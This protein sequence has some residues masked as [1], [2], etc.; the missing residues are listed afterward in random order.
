MKTAIQN[1]NVGQGLAPK[2]K[3]AAIYVRCS[4]DEAGKE[5]YSPETQEEKIK[6]FAKNE[7]W[8][9]NEESLYKDIGF[10]GGT[11]K[12]PDLQRLLKDA[13][14]KKIDVIIVYRMD[15]FFRNL[16]LLLNTVAE[17]RDIGIE[18]K[19]VTEPFD[20]STP[21]GRAMFANAGVFAEWMREVGL[22]SRNEG[23]VKAMKE[24]KYLGGTAPYGCKFN[25]ET[26]KLEIEK[27]EIKIVKMMFEWL[28][29]EGLSEYKIQQRLNTMKVPTKFDLIGRKKITET[30]G[31]WNRKTVDRILS[32]EVYTGTFYY[33]KYL[34]TGRTKN[35]SNLRPKEDWIKVEDKSLKVISKE[36]FEKGQK[37]LKK[38]K[39]Q[40]IRN[41]KEIYTLQ[42]K[43]VCGYD[44]YKYQ[45]ANRKYKTDEGEKRKTKYYFCV[46]NRSYMTARRCHVP[47]VSE[48][49]IMPPVWDKLKEILIE[50]EMALKQIE[51][52]KNQGDD[53]NIP[54]RLDIIKKELSAQDEKKERYAE[55]Y[56]EKSISKNFYDKKIK[57]CDDKAEKLH[58]E[59]AKIGRIATSE[60]EKE[61]QIMSIKDIY[62]QLKDGLENATYEEKREVLQDLV[63]KV[64]K[65]DDK[66]EIEFLIPLR[67]EKGQ[68]RL[69][70]CSDNPRMD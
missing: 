42:H 66:L 1:Y 67:G 13:R 16:R 17:L 49:R 34:H 5:G 33:R 29:S 37:Q 26:Q 27:N 52:C 43:I 28:V 41:T 2:I 47:T 51:A 62:E 6:S 31:W 20:T 22:E 7:G 56:A 9:I 40:A 57:E 8:E 48:S 15:R 3:R 11:E 36:I 19:S 54:E 10:S 12:R 55:L 38:N 61:I 53:T 39:E 30:K 46:G 65:T 24:G 69:S 45:S 50:P 35:E 60:Q 44:G 4:S 23:M 32:N 21:T 58:E 64:V 63:E 18:F 59:D 25:K 68:E 70:D 14:N